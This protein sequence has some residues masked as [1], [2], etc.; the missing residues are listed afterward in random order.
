MQRLSTEDAVAA[1]ATI[2]SP[3]PPSASPTP[4][5]EYYR[6]LADAATAFVK[7]AQDSRRIHTGMPILDAQMRG[8]GAGH[9]CLIVGY[10]HSGKTQVLL[11]WLRHNRDKRIAMFIP[12]EP[13]P[14]VLTKL[15]AVTHKIAARD[16]E[17]RVAANDR[18]AIDMLRRTATD[19]FP[20]LAVFDKPLTPSVLERGYNEVS[21]VWGAEPD[22]VIVDYVDLVQTG[23]DTAQSK[24]DLL[25]GFGSRHE[26]PMI[27][28]H[29]TS[30]SSGAEGRRLT[31]SSGNYGGEQHATFLV[32][33][34]RKRSAIMAEID[35]QRE[36][37]ERGSEAA[38]DKISELEH[39]ARIHQYTMTVSLLKNKRPGG[40]LVDEFDLEIDQDTG[41]LYEL[42]PGDLPSQHLYQLEHDKMIRHEQASKS[43]PWNPTSWTQPEIAYEGEF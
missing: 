10:S 3:T 2:E 8:I 35:L 32:G 18:D 28:I 5:Y 27:A 16:L 34:R 17:A 19:E 14:L 13:A 37:A 42:A 1:W 31:I 30:R 6:P 7:E 12:D 23:G 11:S 39:D 22:L 15:T 38:Y 21:D 25:K 4:K 33:V 24:F 20:N 43:G 40:G 41:A 9:L 29:Q 26:V 36:K